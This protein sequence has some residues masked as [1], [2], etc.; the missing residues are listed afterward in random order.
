MGRFCIL[1]AR[2]RPNEAFVGKGE[3]A[4]ICRWCRRLPRTMRVALKCE[5]EILGFLEQQSHVSHQNPEPGA[6]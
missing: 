2:T 1:R 5:Q 4:R 6:A 3:R